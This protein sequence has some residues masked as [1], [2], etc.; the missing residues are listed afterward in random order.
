[1]K[2]T[3][4]YTAIDQ[5]H[6]W[7]PYTRHSAVEEGLPLL[8]RGEGCYLFDDQGTRYFDGT[9]SWWCCALGHSHP[10]IVE[11]ISEQ[12]KDLQQ[13]I[14]GNLSHPKAI[15]L[16]GQLAQLMPDPQRHVHFASDGSSAIEAALKISVQYRYNQGHPER[17][18]FASLQ[19]A[20]HGDT[21]ATV[22]L[23][24]IEEF[25][26]PFS[27]VRN[28]CH[29]L[30]VPPYDAEPAAAREAAK[31]LFE[32]HGHELA[33]MVVEPLCQGAAG[34]RI[35]EASYLAYL[36][37]LCRE[38][39]VLLIVDEVA[40]GF[41]RTGT[42]FAFEQAGIDPDIVCVG[43]A[44]SAGYLPIS[45][46]IVRDA[47]YDTFTDGEKDCTFY[48]G[49][50]FAGNPLC[51]AAA[52]AALKVYQEEDLPTRAAELNKVLADGLEA[53]R[54]LDG[55]K[56]VRCLGLIGAV[57][58][59]PVPPGEEAPTR[60]AQTLLK[61][62]GILVRPLGQTLYLM[63]PLNTPRPL[64]AETTARFTEAIRNVL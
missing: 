9:S 50:T 32:T 5:A 27:R 26:R 53:L 4:P 17:F 62:E 24:F 11:A 64:L 10:R 23:G 29:Q 14:L 36:N 55:V 56:D 52:V 6:L 47:I 54:P 15:E 1:M 40:T 45:A 63:P 18:R 48:H 43:K 60:K 7:H 39:D 51:A 35:Y 33:A 30:P 3:S 20:Y 22:S 42:M 31:T 41:G 44:L 21:L 58:F 34:I 28:A 57:E 2:S 61:A 13:S 25:H 38:H 16:A 8:V 19:E 37:E 12:A 49:H 59:E 46:A